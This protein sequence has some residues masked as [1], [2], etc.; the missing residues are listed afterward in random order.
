M[1][2]SSTVTE[3]ETATESSTASE[4]PQKEAT[5]SKTEESERKETDLADESDE[6]GI[7]HTF[8]ALAR[9]VTP[10]RIRDDTG[11]DAKEITHGG[12]EE[13]A[14]SGAPPEEEGDEPWYKM[15][16]LKSNFAGK[17]KGFFG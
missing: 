3:S 10:K 7:V 11:K 4:N 13:A 6:E 14:A 9:A 1:T 16:A 12:V 2:G 5:N 17:K 15:T 8:R